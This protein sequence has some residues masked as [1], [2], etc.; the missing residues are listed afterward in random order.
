MVDPEF[1]VP[2][3]LEELILA[4]DFGQYADASGELNV[5]SSTEQTSQVVTLDL[6]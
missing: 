5:V 3:K 6:Q 1:V 2:E 4:R